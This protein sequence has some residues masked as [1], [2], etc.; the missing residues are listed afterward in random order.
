MG[1][2]RHFPEDGATS[3]FEEEAQEDDAVVSRFSL[4]RPASGAR[5]R[6]LR[7]SHLQFTTQG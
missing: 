1:S 5:S 4:T 6:F 2:R 3:G 7:L